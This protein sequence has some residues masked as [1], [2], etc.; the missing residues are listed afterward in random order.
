MTETAISLIGNFLLPYLVLS[1]LAMLLVELI[2]AV[3]QLRGTTLRRFIRH[4]LGDSEGK[5][6]ASELYD[7]YLVRALALST[8]LPSY[9]PTRL[10][11]VALR[12]VVQRPVSE[13][14]LADT[15]VAAPNHDLRQGIRQM[16]HDPVPGRELAAIELWYREVMDGA[17][18]FYRL[19]TLFLVMIVASAMVVSVNFDAIRISNFVARRALIEKGYEAQL[20]ARSSPDSV[21]AGRAGDNSGINYEGLA[22]PIGWSGD[23]VTRVPRSR[24]YSSNWLILKVVGLSTSILAIML[25]ASFLFDLLN[26]F[27]VVRSTTKPWEGPADPS[28]PSRPMGISPMPPASVE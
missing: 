23:G 3:A 5:G 27:M 20:R 6:I 10:F 1:L 2:A 22:F 25:G 18:G 4:M 14:G 12:D 7:H 24:D 8:R 19:R 15:A 16:L 9:I 28:L 11:A 21:P 17:S 13:S 26:R